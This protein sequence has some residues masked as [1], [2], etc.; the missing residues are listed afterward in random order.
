MAAE[1]HIDLLGQPDTLLT[2]SSDTESKE[3]FNQLLLSSQ[4]AISVGL[5][6]ERSIEN[7]ICMQNALQLHQHHDVFDIID[8]A[9]V[10][11]QSRMCNLVKTELTI[12]T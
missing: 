11:L 10:E 1:P 6:T 5:H 8:A 7:L 2:D 4:L 9:L 3:L 12:Q